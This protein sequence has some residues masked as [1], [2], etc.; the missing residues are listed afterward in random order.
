MVQ[1]REEENMAR[2]S[3]GAR[4]SSCQFGSVA[5]ESEVGRRFTGSKMTKGLLH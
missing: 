5:C 2:G 3:G 1:F 4:S